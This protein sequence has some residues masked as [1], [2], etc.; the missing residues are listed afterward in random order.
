M[1]WPSQG[2][3]PIKFCFLT[4]IIHFESFGMRFI[5]LSLRWSP[6]QLGAKRHYDFFENILRHKPQFWFKLTILYLLNALR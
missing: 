6:I 1:I 3:Y 2:E 5:S 4:V